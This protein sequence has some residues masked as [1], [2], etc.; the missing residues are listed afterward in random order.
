MHKLLEEGVLQRLYR[1]EMDGRELVQPLVW[2]VVARQLFR[3]EK[4]PESAEGALRSPAEVAPPGEQTSPIFQRVVSPTKLKRLYNSS[5]L[6]GGH[7]NWKDVMRAEAFQ[8]PASSVFS[9]QIDLSYAPV[10]RELDPSALIP[11]LD[12]GGPLRVEVYYRALDRYPGGNNDSFTLRYSIR[13]EYDEIKGVAFDHHSNW[14]GAHSVGGGPL[15]DVQATLV[16]GDF[17]RRL[18]AKLK[19]AVQAADEGNKW[20]DAGR[21]FL[22]WNVVDEK[23]KDTEEYD[24]EWS[25]VEILV[26][27][28]PHFDMP[29]TCEQFASLPAELRARVHT[30]LRALSHEPGASGFDNSQESGLPPE[31]ANTVVR[32]VVNSADIPEICML[33]AHQAAVMG[34]QHRHET[35][36]KAVSATNE[37]RKLPR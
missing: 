22:E 26:F 13:I 16:D 15:E 25:S 24:T 2:D 34:R 9:T 30:A 36:E 6:T 12:C 35:H 32:E 18:V 33:R 1:E 21:G 37:Q 7:N 29:F 28:R 31:I 23:T 17:A 19:A 10:A 27:A 11:T 4:P 8:H 3:Q 14:D 20:S 5:R